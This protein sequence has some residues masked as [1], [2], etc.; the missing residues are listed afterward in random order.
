MSQNGQTHFK[1]LAANGARFL[2]C[3]WPFWDITHERVKS[4]VIV[5]ECITDQRDTSKYNS[6]LNLICALNVYLNDE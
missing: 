4:A 3:V 6:C 2:K 1:N 5:T